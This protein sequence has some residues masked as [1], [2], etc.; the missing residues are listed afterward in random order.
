MGYYSKR[1]LTKFL[2][3]LFTCITINFLKT[4]IPGTHI[5]SLPNFS[6]S[7]PKGKAGR[8]KRGG[9]TQMTI[10][11]HIT[12]KHKSYGPKFWSYFV[13]EQIQDTLLYKDLKWFQMIDMW[14]QNSV[15]QWNTDLKTRKVV[16]LIP[17]THS[18]VPR[19]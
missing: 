15:A 18:G 4:H 10:W 5:I 14:Q 13:Q 3:A 17:V 2:T 8:T 7:M 6:S 16:N 19:E 9:K 11:N 12:E 1:T